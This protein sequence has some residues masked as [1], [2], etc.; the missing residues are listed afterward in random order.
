ML[1]NME[2]REVIFLKDYRRADVDGMMK[3]GKINTLLESK[4]V[5][6]IVPFG[7]GNDV[8]NHT[9]ISHTLIDEKLKC[10]SRVIVLFKQYRMSLDVVAQFLASFNPSWVFLSA[11]ANAMMNTNILC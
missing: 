8:Y 2:T 6:N 5:P 10:W 1:V 4:G 7:K 11:I 3:E 9:S